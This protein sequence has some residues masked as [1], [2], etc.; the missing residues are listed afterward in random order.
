MNNTA[1]KIKK[2]LNEKEIIFFERGF[3]D[4]TILILPYKLN[5]YGLRIDIMMDIDNLKNRYTL[6]FECILNEE[7]D[8]KE[9]LLNMNAELPS[10]TIA[11]RPNSNIVTFTLNSFYDDDFTFDTYKND[12]YLCFFVFLR[13]YREN[14]INKTGCEVQDE[15]E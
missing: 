12:L 14:I 10:G 8:S 4:S 2:V 5:K 11:I 6:S 9:K 1:D 3:E 15:E 7:I 13:L